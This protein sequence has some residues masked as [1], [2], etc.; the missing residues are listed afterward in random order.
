MQFTINSKSLLSRLVSASK[1]M[2][3]KSPLQIL[4]CFHLQVKSLDL[5]V[6]ASDTENSVTT[7]L[8]LESAEGEGQIC[9]NAKRLLEL[10][11]AMPDSPLRIT[12]N[13]ATNGV[14]V[15]F[16]NGKYE[17]QG[18]PGEEYPQ[19]GNNE[20]GEGATSFS[21]GALH[22]SN[23]LDNVDF[24]MSED[25]LRPQMCGILWDVNPEAV[26]YVATDTHV[27]AKFRDTRSA[28]G[29][30]TS[31][32]L[33]RRVIPVLRAFIA[34]Q[35]SI[36]VSDYSTYVEFKGEGFTLS[37]SK[38][39]GRY[40]DYNRVIPQG[41]TTQATTSTEDFSKAVQR[42]SIC[43]DATTSL[44]KLTYGRDSLDVQAQDLNFSTSGMERILADTEGA[45][46]KVGFN[47]TYLKG[48]LG[49]IASEKVV[50]RFDGPSRAAIFLPSENPE[51][52]ELTLL[53]MPM[54]IR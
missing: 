10:L 1:V 45:A 15:R 37:A 3:P 26:V 17:L 33:H 18:D 32:I 34:K 42:M 6:T 16:S 7:I 51:G 47:A 4:Q 24:A 11:K 22:I 46:V 23:A 29:V 31:F 20:S 13:E 38:L 9:I 36:A 14:E 2:T 28:P 27:L 39:R 44:V 12:V 54:A 52:T 48:V 8:P 53:C 35:S 49:A 40:P 19:R 43:T 30:T 5:H 50:Q 25:E 41:F 21:L